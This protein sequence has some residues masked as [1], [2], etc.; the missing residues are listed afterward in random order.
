MATSGNGWTVLENDSKLLYSWSVPHAHGTKL[1]LRQGSAGFLLVHLATRFNDTVEGLK[2]P[3]LDDWGHAYRPVRGYASWSNHASGTA[4]DLN[5][6]DH[7]LGHSGTFSKQE[8]AKI[9]RILQRYQGCIR[10]GGDYRTRA[11]EMHF[12]INAS[13]SRCEQV[14]KE[15]VGSERGELILDANEGQRR[16][17]YS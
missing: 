10:W 1:K 7:P 12:E 16:V 14:A 6:T 8:E 3:L 11:D 2:E 5:A 15:L 17:I 9:R 4:M 13:L